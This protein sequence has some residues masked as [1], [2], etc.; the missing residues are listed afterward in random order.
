MCGICPKIGMSI[1]S[2]NHRIKVFVMLSQHIPVSSQEINIME[3]CAMHVSA[4]GV[5]SHDF[6][7][8]P[9]EKFRDCLNCEE[10]VC[11]KGLGKDNAEAQAAIKEAYTAKKSGLKVHGP[12]TAMPSSLAVA[13]QR[14]ARLQ[15]EN[16]ELTMR[17]DALLEQ[18]VKWQYNAYKHGLKKHQ[19]NVELP[20]I[21]RERTDG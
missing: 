13:A 20:R 5:C 9:C 17:N 14:I 18:F 19:L 7:M 3:W 11:I 8:S 15:T 21:N 2:R 16:D 6:I 1:R 12:R 10:H 4:W